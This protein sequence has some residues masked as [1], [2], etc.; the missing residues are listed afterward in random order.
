MGGIRG[1]LG[2]RLR[3]VRVGVVEAPLLDVF[4]VAVGR[5]SSAA[6]A[7]EGAWDLERDAGAT[8]WAGFIALARQQG[9]GQGGQQGA[10]DVP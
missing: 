1:R 3:G 10:A 7:V 6:G 4:G 9:L 5:S 2:R 8:R